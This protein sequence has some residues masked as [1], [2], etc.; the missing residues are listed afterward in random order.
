M[1]NKKVCYGPGLD[2]GEGI[3]QYSRRTIEDLRIR[4]NDLYAVAHNIADV[5]WLLVVVMPRSLCDLMVW[6]LTVW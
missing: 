4:C 6:P 3:I 2:R 1:S 5:F